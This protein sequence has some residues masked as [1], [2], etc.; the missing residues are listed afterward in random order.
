MPQH[1]DGSEDDPIGF[2]EEIERS[3]RIYLAAFKQDVFP[4][5]EEYNMSFDA[6]LNVWELNRMKNAINNLANDE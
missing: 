5:F 4:M 6:A 1:I 3:W 2:T